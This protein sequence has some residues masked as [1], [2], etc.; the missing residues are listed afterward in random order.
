MVNDQVPKIY[1]DTSVWIAWNRNQHNAKKF[2]TQMLREAEIGNYEIILSTLAIAEFA[3][4]K[5]EQDDAIFEQ[6]LRRPSFLVVS[7]I[8]P[9]AE[10]ARDLTRKFGGQG[11]RGADASH[12][13]TAIYS[14]SQYLFSYDNHLLGISDKISELKICEPEWPGGQFKIEYESSIRSNVIP[15]NNNL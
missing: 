13:A 2:C 10:I 7:L 11:L 8:R 1:W 9:I 5:K 12:L 14:R 4:T 6:Y 3:P 15:I